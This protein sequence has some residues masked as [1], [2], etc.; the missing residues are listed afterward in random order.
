MAGAAVAIIEG[1]RAAM[2]RQTTRA[3][4][5]SIVSFALEAW[6]ALRSVRTPDI[7]ASFRAV[8]RTRRDCGAMLSATSWRLHRVIAV[9][10]AR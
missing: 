6:R 9:P 5:R 3:V 2:M 1:A 4:D 8:V 7:S 10:R